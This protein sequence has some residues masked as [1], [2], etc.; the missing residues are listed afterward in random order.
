[1]HKPVDFSPK[2]LAEWYAGEL[3][4]R[5]L[6]FW[7]A[8]SPDLEWG[9]YFSCLDQQGKVYDTDKFVWLQARQV[10]TFSMLYNRLDARKEWL[11]MARL[12]ADFLRSHA[13][14]A[15]G[16]FYFAL[17]RQGRPLVQ[18]YNIFANC[19]AALA[20]HEYALASGEE[21]YLSLARQ[22]F[23]RIWARKDHP[24]G[25]YEKST[26]QRPLKGFAL[27]MI[28]ANLMLEMGD[29]LPAQQT[30]SVVAHCIREVMEVF[31]DADSGLI[32]EYVLPNG[33][34][35]DTFKGRLINPGHGIEALWF[36]MDLAW[37]QNDQQLLRLAVQRS[38]D[39]LRYGWDPTYGGIFYFLDAKGAPP[40]QLE[41]DQKLWW[42]HLETL[43]ALA[44]A[45]RYTRRPEV[46]AAYQ[47]VHL[48]TWQHFPDAQDGEW[49]G[50]LNRRGEVLLP[51]KGGKWKGCYHLPRALFEC[52]KVFEALARESST[53]PA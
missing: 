40:E 37:T 50:Y 47:Q 52:W 44:K 10:W 18:P 24:K 43:V 35:P 15:Q 14:D 46:W 9:G 30:R 2:A 21:G 31:Y 7:M 39:L 19:F 22:T 51:L 5:V 16:D 12:G 13:M 26:G 28:L 25:P 11:Q 33:Q 6:P 23:N 38:L 49:W 36:I 42:V 20:F 29:L 53:R 4:G 32:H 48:Y 3:L 34:W 17:D 27:P 8:H 41:W 45:Y 1:M